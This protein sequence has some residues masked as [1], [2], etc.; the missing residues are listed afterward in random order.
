MQP[1]PPPPPPSRL[2]SNPTSSDVPILSPEGHSRMFKKTRKTD[3]Y[4]N[5]SW[6]AGDSS[7]STSCVCRHR[8]MT[9][10]EIPKITTSTNHTH[11]SPPTMS[12]LPVGCTVGLTGGF[13]VVLASAVA[14]RI[15]VFGVD[16]S[17]VVCWT[18]DSTYVVEVVGDTVVV[19]V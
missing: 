1:H 2:H 6:S 5:S 19:L 9:M 18:V 17:L 14:F 10:T 4:T 15:G 11:P 16:L 7:K 8:L 12:V 3:Y 13:A